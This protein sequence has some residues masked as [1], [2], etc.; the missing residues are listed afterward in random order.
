MV[1]PPFLL[2]LAYPGVTWHQ[3]RKEKV[4]YLTFDD[5]PIP[6]VTPKVLALLEQYNAKATF[7]CI[8]DNVKKHPDVY[9]SLLVH[10]HATGNHTFHHYNSWN[11]SAKYFLKDVEDA[12]QLIAS[13]LFRP[14]YGKLT[15]A[16]LFH[17]HRNYKIIMWDVISC[18]FDVTVSKET[19]Y[20]N[21]IT[22]ARE[23]SIIVFHDSLKASENMLYALPK[24]LQYFSERGFKFEKLG[25]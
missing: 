16:T 13:N 9:A 11:V 2:R 4:L 22:H 20:N 3:S 12:K 6:E 1:S 5:G 8:G 19:V 7:F 25:E 21:V 24:V 23:G 18:D 10:G 14:P 17:L 15:P